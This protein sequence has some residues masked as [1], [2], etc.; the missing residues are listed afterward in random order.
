MLVT[1]IVFDFEFQACLFLSD[2]SSKFHPSFSGCFWNFNINNASNL[3]V[4]YCKNRRCWTKI[5]WCYFVEILGWTGGNIEMSAGAEQSPAGRHHL[6]C[7]LARKWCFGSKLSGVKLFKLT[8]WN[9]ELITD[10]Q[11]DG[12]TYTELLEIYLHFFPAGFKLIYIN[13]FSLGLKQE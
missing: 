3:S 8:T 5:Y 4:I 2:F 7:W 1:E 9:W 11:A 12:R 6:H 10:G 13:Q